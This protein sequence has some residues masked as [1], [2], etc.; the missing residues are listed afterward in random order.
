MHIVIGEQIGWHL[1]MLAETLR[2]SHYVGSEIRREK[3]RAKYYSV[4]G[5]K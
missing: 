1:S 4:V 3:M 2:R 5:L